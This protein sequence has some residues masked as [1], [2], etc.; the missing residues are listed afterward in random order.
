MISLTLAGVLLDTVEE[1]WKPGIVSSIIALCLY[2]R[3]AMAHVVLDFPK[4]GESF[5]IGNTITIQW[6]EELNHGEANWDLLFSQ[7]AGETWDTI[8]ADIDL[9]TLEYHWDPMVET[10]AGI[11]RIIQDNAMGLIYNADSEP[12]EIR[13]LSTSVVDVDP[14]RFS[15]QVFPNPLRF[16]GVARFSTTLQRDVTLD[17]IDREGR[18]LTT[19]YS[20][21]LEGGTHSIP[22]QSSD[23]PQGLYYCRITD[24]EF[25][26]SKKVLVVH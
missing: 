11:I 20:G 12:F 15:L 18:Y 23:F 10:D 25:I 6:T 26:Q 13:S 24:G 9:M 2:G 5:Q 14:G 22:F 21:H 3:V 19:I 4:G 16:G 1:M 7:D 8:R 17:L